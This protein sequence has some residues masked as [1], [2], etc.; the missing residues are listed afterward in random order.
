[1]RKGGRYRD[2]KVVVSDVDEYRNAIRR[3]FSLFDIPFYLDEKYSLDSH[4]LCRFIS[5][6]SE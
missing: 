1:M 5:D 6:F 4:A 3:Y 2:V